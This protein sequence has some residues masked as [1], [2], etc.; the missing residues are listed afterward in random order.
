MRVVNPA[1]AREVR[2]ANLMAMGIA[3]E[4]SRSYTTARRSARKKSQG[5]IAELQKQIALP[6]GQAQVVRR[7]AAADAGEGGLRG[8]QPRNGVCPN[9]PAR[10]PSAEPSVLSWW[11]PNVK[12]S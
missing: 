5:M 6:W 7:G 11:H 2:R 8:R 9:R 10:R 1:L 12:V 4:Q 3:L